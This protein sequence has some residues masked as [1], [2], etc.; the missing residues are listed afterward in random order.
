[1]PKPNTTERESLLKDIDFCVFTQ[2]NRENL[3]RLLNSIAKHYAGA[4][5]YIA[6]STLD[7]DRSYYK[8]LRVELEQAGLINRMV[9][10]Q[11]ANKAGA[12][13]ARN[14]LMSNTQNKYKVFFDDTDV[15]TEKTRIEDMAAVLEAHKTIGVASGTFEEGTVRHTPQPDGDEYTTDGMTVYKTKEVNRFMVVVRDL[16]NY[17]R[18]DS[19]AKDYI[20]T[21]SERMAK[22]PYQMVALR[23][24]ILTS[25]I[26]KNEATQPGVQTEKG[27][28]SNGN[29]NGNT[30]ESNVPSGNAPIGGDQKGTPSGKD[31]TRKDPTNGGR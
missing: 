8:K 21:F 13:A 5:V 20:A 1:M 3:E 12:A 30:P 6:D 7:L 4:K 15:L 25:I 10:Y 23:G 27:T 9:V 18:F 29:G 17:I 19:N 16:Q 24:S 22:V 26:T 11:L 31:E 2:G 14:Y 28:E